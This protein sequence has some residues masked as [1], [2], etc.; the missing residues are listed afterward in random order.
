[1]RVALATSAALPDLDADDR[2]LVPAFLERGVSAE[3]VVWDDV[4]VDWS[5]FD[6]VVIRSTWD[7]SDRRD[8]FVA[9]ADEVA[10]AV[11]LFNSAET[12]Q[13][14]T[15]KGYLREL[16]DAGV[17]TVPTVWLPRGGE[18]DVPADW[19]TVV[20]KP[21][22]SASAQGLLRGQRDDP[23]LQA[24]L[25]TLLSESDVMVQPYLPAVEREG[26]VSV[27][28]IDGAI[29]HAVRKMPAPGAFRVQFRLGGVAKVTDV[30]DAMRRHTIEVLAAAPHARDALY[31]RVDLLPTDDGPV[32]IELELV[33][34]CLFFTSAPHA[35]GE[36]A[37]ALLARMG[38]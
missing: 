12:V 26:E 18:P 33:E 2:P 34:P 3:P 23:R 5:T 32:V 9:W 21:A 30:T 6:A 15:H 28:T 35:A 25:S 37:D 38:R 17:P 29:S 36:L 7:Y 1:M 8:H 14:N 4:D 22:V 19:A 13:W 24:H 16:A 20:V 11:P 10:G 27:V 31:A